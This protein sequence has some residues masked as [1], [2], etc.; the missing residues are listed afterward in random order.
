M[1]IG[2]LANRKT[3]EREIEGSNLIKSNDDTHIRKTNDKGFS[4]R[5]NT[6]LEI[7]AQMCK[8][9]LNSFHCEVTR[10]EALPWCYYWN[11]DAGNR[12]CQ[13]VIRWDMRCGRIHLYMYKLDLHVLSVECIHTK[14]YGRE[15]T[16]AWNIYS[17]VHRSCFI[18]SCN[19]P[20]RNIIN[21]YFLLSFATHSLELVWC[22]IYVHH[23]TRKYNTYYEIDGY[24]EL[25]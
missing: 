12:Y 15:K 24:Y 10:L 9:R 8:D 1:H 14:C 11:S 7:Q 16:R 18:W 17:E 22:A 2:T 19:F 3:L 5:G 6:K 13:E 21:Y 20:T 4:D 25:A 23:T